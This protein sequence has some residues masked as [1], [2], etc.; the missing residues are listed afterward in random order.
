MKQKI[1]PD[2][3]NKFK[4]VSLIQLFSTNQLFINLLFI[5]L[6]TQI[7]LFTSFSYLLKNRSRARFFG[8]DQEPVWKHPNVV[9]DQTSGPVEESRLQLAHLQ[10]GI[11]SYQTPTRISLPLAPLCFW[12][13]LS[14]SAILVAIMQEMTCDGFLDSAGSTDLSASLCW[15]YQA[16]PFLPEPARCYRSW[17]TLTLG[18]VTLV[19]R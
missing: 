16:N 2:V 19:S 14:E 12:G 3:Q 17:W 6:M 1:H 15:S 9:P 10:T 5:S 8:L 18:R 11:S 4:L 13:S 7:Y